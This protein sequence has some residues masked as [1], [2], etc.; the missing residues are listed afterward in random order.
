MPRTDLL[1]KEKQQTIKN[2][3]RA[4]IESGTVTFKPTILKEEA[5]GK[6][7]A[8]IVC[9]HS[10]KENNEDKHC[11]AIYCTQK[12]NPGFKKHLRKKHKSDY[13]AVESKKLKLKKDEVIDR[14]MEIESKND[15][16]KIEAKI[17]AQNLR[18]FLLV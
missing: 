10:R 3:V 1:T 5:V 4:G 18:P 7:D 8:W 12:G 2:D 15:V 13:E 14:K 17:F 16:A 9:R 11:N 6:Y